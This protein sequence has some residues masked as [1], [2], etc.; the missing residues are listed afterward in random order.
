MKK[1]WKTFALVAAVAAVG[2][3]GV[4]TNQQA[5]AMSDLMLENIEALAKIEN[6]DGSI[7][8][9]DCDTYCQPDWRYT[10]FISWGAGIDGVTCPGYRAKQKQ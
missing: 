10:C 5:A 3:Y 8:S 1:K 9:S 2:G 7:G 4:Y 6:G